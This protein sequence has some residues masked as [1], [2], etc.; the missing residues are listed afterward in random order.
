M[1][2]ANDWYVVPKGRKEFMLNI[3]LR[4]AKPMLVRVNGKL[5][6]LS[7]VITWKF[8]SLD[9]ATNNLPM[10]DGFLPP[11][12]NAPEGEGAVE[13]T[14]SLIASVPNGKAVRSRAEIIFDENLPIITNT[15]ENIVDRVPP[16]SSLSATVDNYR[17]IYIT[18]AS[19]DDL[20]GTEVYNLYVKQASG[21]WM[22]LTGTTADTLTLKGETGE[23]YHFYSV[24]A[25]RVGN[26]ELKTPVAEATVTVVG[27]KEKPALT[28]T[29]FVLMPNP[30]TGSVTLAT[31]YDWGNVW[32]EVVN[33]TG[34][35]V[36]QQHATLT[37]GG[38]INIGLGHIPPG[39]Y[40]VKMRTD[41]NGKAGMQKL[42]ISR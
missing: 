14:V 25:D 12:V 38:V 29:P 18:F 30:A 20:S 17:N 9:P 4:P 15:W 27:I 21:P 37:A 41:D 33:M 8:I 6:T 22:S 42:V 3:D 1:L 11:N 39:L 31:D 28:S 32:I 24:A 10:L 26:R 7:G 16:V 35:T 23:T 5:D 13:Y 19:T 34:Q 36:L 2:I 40:M